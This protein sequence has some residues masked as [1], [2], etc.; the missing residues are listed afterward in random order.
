MNSSNN[1]N[2]YIVGEGTLPIQCAEILLDRG[3]A[4]YGIF[5]SDSAISDWARE[6]GIPHIDPMNNS[7]TTVLNQHP[8]AYLFS[9]ASPYILPKQILELPRRCAINYH[10]AP[11]P[12]MQGAMQRPGLLCKVKEFMES[13][14]IS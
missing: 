7:I 5:S 6:R 9:I 11:L 4:I 3:H 13:H 2:C 10:D 12:N 14:G 8:F 1:F